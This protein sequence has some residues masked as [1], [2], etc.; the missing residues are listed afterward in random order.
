MKY[1]MK[2]KKETER[3]TIRRITIKRKSRE[4]IIKDVGQFKSCQ[5]EFYDALSWHWRGI[6]TMAGAF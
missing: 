3:A 4:D 5:N 2:G 6:L 1:E